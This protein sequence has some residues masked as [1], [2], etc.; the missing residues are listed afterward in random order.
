MTS[1]ASQFSCHDDYDPNAL[2]VDLGRQ[3]I[4]DTLTPITGIE[5]FTNP[6]NIALTETRP[7]HLKRLERPQQ[8]RNLTI[9]G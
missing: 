5:Q 2:A 3:L 7:V 9:A 8:P 4:L 1:L 6:L